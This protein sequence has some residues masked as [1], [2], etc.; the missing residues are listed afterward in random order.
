[1]H[2][3]SQALQFPAPALTMKELKRMSQILSIILAVR[4]QFSFRIMLTESD[5]IC[6][7]FLDPYNYS[8][9]YTGRIGQVQG[10]VINSIIL[11]DTEINLPY[12][13]FGCHVLVPVN[14]LGSREQL[15]FNKC[16]QGIERSD[17]HRLKFRRSLL[18]A[19]DH[20]YKLVPLHRWWFEYIGICRT[21][22]QSYSTTE[23]KSMHAQVFLS[24]LK[25]HV[26]IIY[27]HVW[28]YPLIY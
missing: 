9:Y 15:F 28:H 6:G 11:C 4:L 27:M 26:Y 7:P 24:P 25:Q 5:S 21:G 20:T 22:M 18:F 2:R 23:S 10:Y 12:C 19:K 1:M 13:F 14:Q 16:N 3:C 8:R 17:T